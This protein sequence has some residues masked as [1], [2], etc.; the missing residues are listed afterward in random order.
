MSA[1]R[2]R[3]AIAR[4]DVEGAMREAHT[5][6][7]LAGNIGASDVAGIA[8]KLEKMLTANDAEGTKPGLRELDRHMQALVQYLSLPVGSEDQGKPTL[9]HTARP[10]RAHQRAETDR[11]AHRWQ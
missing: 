10:S 3:E 7:G 1:A 11:R 5:L 4:G 9:G 2:I 6:K 8:A